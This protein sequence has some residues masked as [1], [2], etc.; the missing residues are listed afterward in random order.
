MYT[1]LKVISTETGGT[2]KTSIGDLG[3]LLEKYL[4]RGRPGMI[5]TQFKR[6][7]TQQGLQVQH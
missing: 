4:F 1:G 5:R 3:V 6:G 2:E 7:F